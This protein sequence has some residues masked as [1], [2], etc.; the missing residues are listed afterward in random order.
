MVFPSWFV[1]NGRKPM[2][3]SVLFLILDPFNV[4]SHHDRIPSL[5]CP[6]VAGPSP[7]FLPVGREDFCRGVN[8]EVLPFSHPAFGDTQNFAKQELSALV[9]GSIQF[10]L[11]LFI[12]LKPEMFALYNHPPPGAAQ[13]SSPSTIPSTDPKRRCLCCPQNQPLSWKGGD[14]GWLL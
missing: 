9:T 6:R 12:L 3:S 13:R 2:A 10:Y 8:T 1:W 4:C 5:A 14:L 11:F 7:W